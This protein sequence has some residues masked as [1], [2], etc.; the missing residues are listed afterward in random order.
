MEENNGVMATSSLF[1]FPDA[2]QSDRMMC[3]TV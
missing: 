1:G 2:T 3:S